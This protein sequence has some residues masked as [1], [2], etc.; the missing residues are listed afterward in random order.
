[1]DPGGTGLGLALFLFLFTS[2]VRAFGHREGFR[3]RSRRNVKYAISHFVIFIPSNFRDRLV[4]TRT[5]A[6]GFSFI[7]SA[8]VIPLLG[9]NRLHFQVV[10]RRLTSRP[11]TQ[12]FTTLTRRLFVLNEVFM[13]RTNHR[14][15]LNSFPR[16]VRPFLLRF[17]VV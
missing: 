3:L 1:M 13:R 16:F 14:F 2:R 11:M 4:I 15:T 12:G 9:Y 10:Y 6:M 5:K 7:P 17:M 8:R